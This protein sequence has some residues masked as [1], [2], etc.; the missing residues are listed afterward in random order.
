MKIE[1]SNKNQWRRI[2]PYYNQIMFLN[3]ITICQSMSVISQNKTYRGYV[4]VLSKDRGFKT[5]NNGFRYSRHLGFHFDE[6]D[7]TSDIKLLCEDECCCY[8]M[9]WALY[10]M[11][12]VMGMHVRCV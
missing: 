6:I 3:C 10:V 1:K 12:Y 9:Y 4:S 11:L 2:H 7:S 5:Q 8:C